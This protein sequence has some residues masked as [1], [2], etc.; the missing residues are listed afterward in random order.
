[1]PCFKEI[2]STRQRREFARSCLIH[3][4]PGGTQILFSP[5]PP[6]H[7]H[8]SSLSPSGWVVMMAH[9]ACMESFV[10]SDSQKKKKK[11]DADTWQVATLCLPSNSRKGGRPL[12]FPTAACSL[13]THMST[14]RVGDWRFLEK[15]HEKKRNTFSKENLAVSIIKCN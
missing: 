6:P 5:R 1:M 14:N 2:T 12:T 8:P 9:I 4:P 7:H 15:G 13:S 11:Q 10:L 3:C